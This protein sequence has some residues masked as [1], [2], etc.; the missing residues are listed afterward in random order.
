QDATLMSAASRERPVAR[1]HFIAVTSAL[2]PKTWDR[3]KELGQWG[4]TESD[5]ISK[6]VQPGDRLLIWLG[7][8][9]FKAIAEF[10][11]G[12]YPV[13]DDEPGWDQSGKKY[14]FR[15]DIAVVKEYEN[16]FKPSFPAGKNEKLG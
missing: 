12:V 5:K 8:V 15:Y 2:Y 14:P 1:N 3:C 4:S 13:G 16:V 10:T 9:G 7:K 6:S 11:S